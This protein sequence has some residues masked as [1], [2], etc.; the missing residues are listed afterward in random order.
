[1]KR[2]LLR[3]ESFRILPGLPGTGPWPEQFSSGGGST[4]REGFVVEFFPPMQP[5]WV[6]NF[7]NGMGGCSAVFSFPSGGP[8]A[9]VAGG[10]GY[11]VAPVG[12]R[13]LRTF[14]GSIS[15]ALTVPEADLLI[16]ANDT[17]LEAW[18][19]NFMHWRTRRISWDGIRELRVENGSI[20]GLAYSPNEFPFEINI[21]TG[22][23]AK[24]HF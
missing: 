5:S 21:R 14:G 18:D 20:K 8:V 7:Q 16:F 2:G 1:M 12:R 11:L 10:E 23:I 6:G 15:S 19:A 3:M 9:V 4:H 13:L 17:E 22:E 24:D